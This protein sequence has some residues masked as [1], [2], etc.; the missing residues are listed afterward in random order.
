MTTILYKYNRTPFSL[1][2]TTIL[3]TDDIMKTNHFVYSLRCKYQEI[4]NK[5]EGAALV[6]VSVY[7]A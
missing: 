1:G 6:V 2:P 4:N 7:F 5:S 3:L